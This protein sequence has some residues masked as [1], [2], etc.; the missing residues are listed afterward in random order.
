MTSCRFCFLDK[1]NDI[2]IGCNIINETTTKNCYDAFVEKSRDYT[3]IGSATDRTALKIEYILC[4][5][6][7][8]LNG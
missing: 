6:F 1:I 5:N 8:T 3:L 7:S 2:F 4:R